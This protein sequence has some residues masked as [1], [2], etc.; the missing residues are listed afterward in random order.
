[1]KTPRHLILINLD[2][3]AEVKKL[4]KIDLREDIIYF[5]KALTYNQIISTI[6]NPY[7]QF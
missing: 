6:H 4:Q 1:M 7:F 2:C 5:T 3:C